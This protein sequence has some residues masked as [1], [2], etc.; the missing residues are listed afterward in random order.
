M[1]DRDAQNGLALLRLMAEAADRRPP[2]WVNRR[3]EQLEFLDTR[4]VRWR[5]S[6]DFTVPAAAPVVRTGR[7]VFRLVPLTSWTKDNLVAFDLRDESGN[8]LWLPTAKDTERMLTEALIRWAGHLM[9][10]TELPNPLK[11]TL[12]AIV[13]ERPPQ[14]QKDHEAKTRE[15]LDPFEAV[16]DHMT[17]DKKRARDDYVTEVPAELVSDP[18][19]QSQISEL[20]R[21]DL[22]VV[23]VA[24]P[25]G[26]RRILKMTFESRFEFGRPKTLRMR[27]VQSLGWRAW[28]MELYIGSR[29]GSHHLEVASPPGIDILR[30]R[31]RP[32]T[33]KPDRRR[34]IVVYGGSPHIHLRIGADLHSR[35][36]ATIRVRVSRPGWLT[37][38]W[39]AGLVIL[40]VLLVGGLKLRALFSAVP[41]AG[42]AASLLLALLA[43]FATMLTGPGA[44]PL[45]SRLLTASR[46]LILIDSVLVLLG[47]GSL[48]LDGQPTA[49]W[50]PWVTALWWLLVAVSGI[51]AVMLTL[52]R[53]FPKAPRE[54]EKKRWKRLRGAMKDTWNWLIGNKDEPGKPDQASLSIPAA[55]GYHYGDDPDHHWDPDSQRALV[56]ALRS[57]EASVGHYGSEPAPT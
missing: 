24:D 3:V 39:L 6:V 52:S 42:T 57:A 51:C 7:K 5:V 30:I 9:H 13:A 55:D 44:H 2:N 26:T 36:L 22:I 35:Y 43:L 38:S 15:M 16:I 34:Y 23:P 17:E 45:A 33:T 46:C 37:T 18:S 49:Q 4:A 14:R 27:A 48:L 1:A 11:E 21:N 32:V 20:W 31:A 50:W 54:V 29:G 19:F 25:P 41:E 10:Q 8:T 53:F 28:R 12:K 40:V 56:D 47:A